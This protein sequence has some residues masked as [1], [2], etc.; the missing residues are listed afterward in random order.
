MHGIQV[1]QDVSCR[2]VGRCT[3]GAHLDNEILDLV[4]RET[5]ERMNKAQQYAAPKV[6]LSTN[7]RRNFLYARYNA[8]L[9][10]EGLDKLGF[11]NVDAGSIQKMDAVQNIPTLTE[12]GRA[13]GKSVDASHFGSFL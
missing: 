5:T 8:E 4:P 6:P 11:E 10:R 13:A 2:T 3:F 12:I 7:L 9:S 1:D